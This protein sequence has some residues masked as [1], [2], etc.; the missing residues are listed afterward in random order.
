MK[1]LEKIKGNVLFDNRYGKIPPQSIDLEE[2][3]IGAILLEKNAYYDVCEILKNEVFYKE[4]H[5]KIYKAFEYLDSKNMPIDLL[6]VIDYLKREEEL[7]NCGGAL[8]LIK[9]TNSVF[10]SANIITH[11]R[12]I[13]QKFIQREIII[14]CSE[15]ITSSYEDGADPFELLSTLESGINKLNGLITNSKLINVEKIA[16]NIISDLEIKS[17]NG[18]NNIENDNEVYTGMKEWDAINGSLFPGLYVVAAR[19]G[20]G[21]TNH[22]VEMICRMGKKTKIGVINGEMTNRQLLT[23]IG[24]NLKSIDNFLWKKNGDLITDDELF[25]VKE[26]MQESINLKIVIDDS[27]NINKIISKIKIWVRQNGVKAILAD[28]LS[29]FKVSEEKKRYMTDL[30][31]LNYVINKFGE[32]AR[33]FNIPIILYAHLNRELYK[34]G[35]KEPMMADLKGSGNIEDFAYQVSF[36]HRPEYYDTD[37]IT[38]ENGEDIKGLMYQIIAKH[39]DG[40]LGRIKY[41]TNLACSQIKEWNNSNYGIT[42]D[43][44]F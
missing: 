32:V 19:P 42:K 34:R 11:A 36:L 22:M 44:P 26:A 24:C 5:Q 2:S 27:T 41:K 43:L 9:L 40:N 3:I 23:R 18:R 13:L 31:E 6:T 39:R 33:E 4:T 15:M 8:Y 30:Q 14:H 7:E 29:K 38:D 37:A 21:K 1:V 16:M 35:S 10:S 17:Y 12:I 20:M 28:V 25:L